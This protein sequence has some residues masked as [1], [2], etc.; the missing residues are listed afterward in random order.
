[1][2]FSL[3]ASLSFTNDE[4]AELCRISRHCQA[5]G[6]ED[7]VTRI[8]AFKLLVFKTCV[9]VSVYLPA[10]LPVYVSG[11]PG[12][13]VLLDGLTSTYTRVYSCICL[14]VLSTCRLL[15]MSIARC[16]IWSDQSRVDESF[17]MKTWMHV[18]C[19]NFCFQTLIF[20]IGWL[21][22]RERITDTRYGSENQT[23]KNEL[24][25]M[26]IEPIQPFNSFSLVWFHCH[27]GSLWFSLSFL[28]FLSL[29]S[30]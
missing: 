2:T 19:L 27:C 20:E 1:M 7:L 4:M 23:K 21:I 30:F 26:R 12:L 13:E 25:R 22:E 6:G 29:S 16:V 11:S 15:C 3:H 5:S 17:G 14:S 8:S 10:C 24:A 28:L 18:S 9:W